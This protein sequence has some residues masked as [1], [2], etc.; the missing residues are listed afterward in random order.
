MKKGNCEG[1]MEYLCPF[2]RQPPPE[3]EEESDKQRIKRLETNDPIALCEEG[4]EQVEKGDYG[5]AFDYFAKSAELGHAEAH[6]EL[7]V[8]YHHGHGVEEDEGKK[9]HHLEEAAIGGHPAARH[10]LGC[11][12]EEVNGHMERSAKHFII[13]ATLGYDCSIKTLTGMFRSGEVSKEVLTAALRAYQAAVNAAKSPQRVVAED[14]ERYEK[15]GWSQILI[16]KT[17][18]EVV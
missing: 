13:A 11:F 2:C 10:N 16:L 7:S 9:M 15:N 1:T 17:I 14:Y 12:E 6:Y 3:T 5:T 4:R 8:L 18:I